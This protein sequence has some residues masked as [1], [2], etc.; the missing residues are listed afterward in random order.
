MLKIACKICKK[1]SSAYPSRKLVYCSMKCRKVDLIAE[2]NPNWKSGRREHRGDGYVLIYF[3]DHP[4]A[5]HGAVYEHRLV[6]ERHLGRYLTRKE[7][8]HHVNGNPSDNRMENLELLKSQNE[9]A[10]SH[11]GQRKINKK[12]QF[13]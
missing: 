2:K 1:I 3:P 8:V 4:H 9:H 13:V 12:G 6:M 7:V 5:S 10:K 11:Y